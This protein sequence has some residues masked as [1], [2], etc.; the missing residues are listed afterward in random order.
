MSLT[1]AVSSSCSQ[2]RYMR[3]MYFSAVAISSSRAGNFCEPAV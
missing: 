1:L 3:W 2:M